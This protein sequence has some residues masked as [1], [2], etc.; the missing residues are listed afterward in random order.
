M[1][2]TVF[3]DTNVLIYARDTSERVKQLGAI[4][5]AGLAVQLQLLLGQ[6]ADKRG[7]CT[8]PHLRGPP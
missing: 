3:V 4:L 7:M 1:S 5:F 6:P 2:A 8:H